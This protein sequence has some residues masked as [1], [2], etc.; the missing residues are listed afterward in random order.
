MKLLA[1]D[2]TEE[3]CS[4]AIYVEGE[5]HARYQLA[6][7]RHSELI[8]PMMESVLAEA[9]ITLLQLDAL[10]FARGPGSFTGLRIAAGIIQGAAVAADLP[11]VPVSSLAALAQGGRRCHGVDKTVAA[12]DARMH[13]VYWAAYQADER[14]LM[15][16]VSADA[17]GK[18]GDVSLPFPGRWAGVGSGWQAYP[19]EMGALV[20]PSTIFPELRVSAEDV[21]SL[22]VAGYKA[23]E[24]IDAAEAVPV[25]LRD[26][27]AEKPRSVR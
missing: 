20:Q 25:Y 9:E 12:F 7:R 15:Q 13:E 10:A 16:A 11:V 14:G 21:V 18:P 26:K 1:I 27:V 5:I 3:S 19:A 2:T 22:A 23:G 6:P 24:A 4:A 8:L 17:L